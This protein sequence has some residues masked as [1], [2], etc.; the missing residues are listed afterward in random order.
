LPLSE[1]L[2]KEETFLTKRKNPKKRENALL[3]WQSRPIQRKYSLY[4]EIQKTLKKVINFFDD[5]I[6][7]N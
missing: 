5:N 4:L 1:K 7:I 6:N 2:S 3:D